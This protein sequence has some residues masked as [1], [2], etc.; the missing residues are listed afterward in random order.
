MCVPLI[1]VIVP[2]YKVEQYLQQCVDSICAQTY[3][4][5]EIILVDD[6]SPDRC[7]QLCDELA[8]TDSRIRVIHKRNGGLSSARNAG[9]EVMQGEYV[10]FV[11]SDDWIDPEM[12]ERLYQDI[13]EHEAQIACCGIARCKGDTVQSYFNP[14]LDEKFCL[15][16]EDAMCELIQNYRIT[17]SVCDKLYHVSIFDGL[18]MKEGILYEDAQIQ[19]L[20]I[21]CAQKVVYDAR[22][23]YCY[24]LSEGSILRG[25]FSL[26]HLDNLNV[27]RERIGFFT[28]YYPELVADAEAMHICL[29]I[30]QI[31]QSAGNPV[32]DSQRKELIRLVRKPVANNVAQKIPKAYRVK[33]GLLCIHERLFMMVMDMH[34]AGKKV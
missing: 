27:S 13:Q 2:V 34:N 17:N 16:V 22:P 10:G 30:N 33:R 23:M 18:R 21:H 15:N 31:Y 8:M 14:K 12:Y 25:T 24:R 26:R 11:D 5:L 7:G 6:G 9:L 20:C 28:E 1:S 29:C 32:W 3:R 4:N 19:P